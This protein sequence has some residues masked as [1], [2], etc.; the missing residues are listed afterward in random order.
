[1]WEGSGSRSIRKPGDLPF[2]PTPPAGCGR[3]A[4]RTPACPRSPPAPP[5][6]GALHFG[7]NPPGRT[8]MRTLLLWAGILG[9]GIPALAQ[10]AAV[11][12]FQDTVVV[13]AALEWEDQAD[14]PASV[15]VTQKEEIEA[16]QSH[17]LADAVS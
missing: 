3:S 11:P 5:S 14:F 4:V 12:Q 7:R 8:R 15:P 1:M 10:T 2:R 17:D 13:S 16:R 6:R 9:G